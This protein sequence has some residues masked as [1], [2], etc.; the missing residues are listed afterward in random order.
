MVRAKPIHSRIQYKRMERGVD[1]SELDTA[2][3]YG[4]VYFGSDR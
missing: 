3:A 1:N 4:K 2:S